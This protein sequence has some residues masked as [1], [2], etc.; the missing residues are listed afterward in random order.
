V[1]KVFRKGGFQ[2]LLVRLI[3]FYGVLHFRPLLS[4]GI[5][6]ITPTALRSQC[7]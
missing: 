2:Y 6:N 4:G 7:G 3:G 1:A 5:H